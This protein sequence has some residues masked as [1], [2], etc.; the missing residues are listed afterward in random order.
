MQVEW[1][2]TLNIRSLFGEIIWGRLH[3]NM[4]DHISLFSSSLGLQGNDC[5]FVNLAAVAGPVAGKQD[6]LM[7]V[8]YRLV[9]FKQIHFILRRAPAAAGMA[10]S[11]LDF[12][13][14]IQS[15]TQATNAERSGQVS[16]F[17]K[18]LS[19]TSGRFLMQELKQCVTTP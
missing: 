9:P 5:V 6:A 13:H 2:I 3:L 14:W 18:L 16:D 1:T 10:C 11:D 8:N 19:F 15:S 7:D 17:P 4:T 12:G